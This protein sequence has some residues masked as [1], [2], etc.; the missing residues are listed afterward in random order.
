MNTS[1]IKTSEFWITAIA[2]IAGAIVAI[3]AARGLLTNEEGDLWIALINAIAVAAVPM[4]LAY[5]NGKYI[6]SRATL[7]SEAIAARVEME[8]INSEAAKQ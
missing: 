1:G 3:L 5:V 8:R 6:E 2:N 4:A 7:K